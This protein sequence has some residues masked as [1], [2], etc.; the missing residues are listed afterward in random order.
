M[1][2]TV[3]Q[4]LELDT[5]RRGRPRVAAGAAGLRRTVRWTHV[6]EHPDIAHL[7]RGGELLLSTGLAF[8]ED[9]AD[10]ADFAVALAALQ[11]VRSPG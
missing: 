8:P 4:V 9:A 6:T 1:Y 7:L 2:P 11:A 3:A 5:L 10:L